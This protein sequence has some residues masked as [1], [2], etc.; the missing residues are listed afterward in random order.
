[1]DVAV[2]VDD[3]AAHL[4]RAADDAAHRLDLC[5]LADAALAAFRTDAQSESLNSIVGPL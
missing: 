4:L 5:A 3:V 1:M 2:N